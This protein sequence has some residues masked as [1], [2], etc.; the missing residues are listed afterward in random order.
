MLKGT[1]RRRLWG[2]NQGPLDSVFDDLPLRLLFFFVPVCTTY[3]VQKF[4]HHLS[5]CTCTCTSTHICTCSS[6]SI[7]LL[8][9]SCC[10][11]LNFNFLR[12]I[13]HTLSLFFSFFLSLS[14]YFLFSFFLFFFF[15]LKKNISVYTRLENILHTPLLYSKTGV[16]RGIPIFLI[17][18]PKLRLWVLVRTASANTL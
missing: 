9:C 15:F 18:A 16:C 12:N 8:C 14:I 10:I 5:P 3:C 1:T 11:L 4:K 7:F 17:F 2:S 6:F 13:V